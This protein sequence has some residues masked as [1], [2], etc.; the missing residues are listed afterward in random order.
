MK[1][2][3]GIINKSI[4]TCYNQII[5]CPLSSSLSTSLQSV[6]SSSQSSSFAD[7]DEDVGDEDV[8]GEDVDDEDVIPFTPLSIEQ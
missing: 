6:L 8:A 3:I 2:N 1:D 4:G 7:D 5:L